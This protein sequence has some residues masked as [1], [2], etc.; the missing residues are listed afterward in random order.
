[1]DREYERVAAW[2]VVEYRL[3]RRIGKDTAVPIKLAVDA[4]TRKGWR[5]CARSHDVLGGELRVTAVEI[6]HLACLNVRRANGEPCWSVMNDR[7]VDEIGQSRFE[8][9]GGIIARLVNRQWN[10]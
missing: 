4:H 3:H 2:V 10:I 9:M 5:Q 8:R 1:M 7:E 6:A